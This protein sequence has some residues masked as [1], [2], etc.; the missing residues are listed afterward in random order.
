MAF[1]LYFA[2]SQHKLT[3]DYMKQ[4][5][6]CRLFS[7]ADSLKGPYDW[8]ETAPNSKLFMD[9]GA[10][11]IF[12]NGAKIDIDQYIEFINST[13]GIE[14]F[15]QLDDIPYPVLTTSSALESSQGSWDKYL[16][17]MERVKDEYRDKV[18]PIYHF[19]EPYEA[20]E[21]ILNTEVEGR[22]APYIGVGGRHGVSNQ[23]HDKYFR[24]I[25][26]IIK[27][28]KNPDVKIHAFGMTVFSLLEKYKFYSADSTS[29]LQ[30]G[31]NGTILTKACG[32]L[33][34]SERQKLKNKHNLFNKPK[35]IFEKIEQEIQSRGYTVDEVA[36]DYKKRLMFNID[37]Y[38]EF[39]D[40]F[41]FKSTQGAKRKRLF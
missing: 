29:W 7:F 18:L 26:G 22:L 39:A 9:S 19:G 13:P 27:Q 25:F 2:G 32:P 17:I 21:R 15:A 4:K 38:K 12:H 5:E 33:S 28:S 34:V 36:K 37:Y 6:C 30:F 3:D 35:G 16:Y 10:F 20:L 41:E 31:V 1:N 8:I 11:S 23:D 40:T 14:V 24:H